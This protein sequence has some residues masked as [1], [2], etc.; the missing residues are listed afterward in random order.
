[1]TVADL[2]NSFCN[3]QSDT[4]DYV[5][6]KTYQDLKLHQ[7]T[8]FYNKTVDTLS[9]ELNNAIQK[10][11]QM[12][13][14]VIINMATFNLVTPNKFLSSTVIENP[15]RLS[16]YTILIE[17]NNNLDDQ[18]V[19][20]EEYINIFIK[21][22]PMAIRPKCL[23]LFL[24]NDLPNENILEKI[25]RYAWSKKFVDFS[26]ISWK[27][28]FNKTSDSHLYYLNPFSNT[29]VRKDNCQIENI[30]PDKL[31]NV[32]KYPFKLLVTIQKPFI[33]FS[34]D[35]YGNK[36][37]EGA[38]YDILKIAIE[39]MNFKLI[40]YY[41]DVKNNT[42]N[43]IV[44]R[45]SHNMLK[46][47]Y[48]NMLP[49][50]IPDYFPG[51]NE[52][53]LGCDYYDPLIAM[54][55]I[56]S[57]TKLELPTYVLISVGLNPLLM[58]GIMH[59]AR[60]LKLHTINIGTFKILQVI[61]G[62]PINLEPKKLPDRIIYLSI[63]LISL[64]YT[65]IYYSQF[66]DV[67]IVEKEDTFETLKDI[68]DSKYD[69]YV[70]KRYYNT[71][72]PNDTEDTLKIKNRAK[73]VSDIFQCLKLI[74]VK[75]VICM[76]NEFYAKY[77]VAKYLDADGKP[78]WK[79]AK[80]LFS[81][82]KFKFSVEHAFPY[83]E[84]FQATFQQVYQNGVWPRA[85]RRIT[86]VIADDSTEMELKSD[87]M[88][89]YELIGMICFGYTLSAVALVTELFVHWLK[90]SDQRVHRILVQSNEV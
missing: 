43:N 45:D 73:P 60:W 19:Q 77:L 53:D 3:M 63:V 51:F 85:A 10:M 26:I 72:L 90:P 14:A 4:I 38:H 35:K 16:L 24:K 56:V 74:Y 71:L 22:S 41:L 64:G 68:A 70:N 23:L 59:V 9:L 17:E 1:M 54:V 89:V 88:V 50:A 80:P 8:I 58:I 37:V 83:T 52:M 86:R 27:Y 29:F 20:V 75:K 44:L 12:N 32:S 18:V 33:S 87:D 62:I 48:V 65:T 2:E 81:Q 69:I 47:G 21:L 66:L 31:I 40:N 30:F 39:K 28:Y 84:K 7:V 67:Q 79:I 36:K 61:F 46:N 49:Q 55:P 76:T 11:I 15:R 25:L 82:G 78:L 6:L 5:A 13:P 42:L 57:Y 34:T